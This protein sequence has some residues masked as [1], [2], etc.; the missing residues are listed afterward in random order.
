LIEKKLKF[1][2][3]IL[4][5][6]ISILFSL[7]KRSLCSAWAA[8]LDKSVGKNFDWPKEVFFFLGQTIGTGRSACTACPSAC[9]SACVNPF[10]CN[11]R[12][13]VVVHLDAAL[14]LTPSSSREFYKSKTKL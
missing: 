6:K 8:V 14:L 9:T 2:L 5:Q 13:L 10:L 11:A 12:A 3:K 7:F 4:K 1:I